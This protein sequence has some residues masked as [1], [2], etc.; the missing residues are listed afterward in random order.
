MR[1]KPAALNSATSIGR[2]AVSKVAPLARRWIGYVLALLPLGLCLYFAGLVNPVAA[3]QPISIR[4]PWAPSLD[5]AFDGLLAR[6]SS[7]R[8]RWRRTAS[9]AAS[10]A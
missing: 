5:V 10:S 1:R 9:A 3:G 4:Y 7:V 6:R 2:S 8:L